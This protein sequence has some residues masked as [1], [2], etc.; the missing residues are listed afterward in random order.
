MRTFVLAAAAAIAFA[1]LTAPASAECASDQSVAVFVTDYLAKTPTWALSVGGTMD[2]AMCSQGK[3]VA[4]L[5]ET[6]GP[7]VGYKAGLTSKK[8]QEVFKADEPVMGVLLRDMILEDGA[9]VPA[10][11]GARPLVEGDLLL[12]VGDEAI[13]DAKTPEEAI[14]SISEVRPFIE[15]PDIPTAQGQP[16]TPVTLT[17]M[18]VGARLGVE[19]APIAVK[20]PDAMLKA[21]ADMTVKITAADGSVLSETKG[22]AVLGNPVNSVLWLRSK[23]VTFKPG[24]IVSVGSMGP[25]LFPDA[26]GGKATATYDGLPGNPSISVT[27]N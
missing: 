2:D 10:L 12:I 23:G 15:L 20:D 1:G 19:G 13:N 4:A 16:L 24:D 7:P 5:S 8:V 17:A 11:F 18:N 25:L 14:R 21:L 9:Q 27:F 26:T 3:L 22:S 6:M